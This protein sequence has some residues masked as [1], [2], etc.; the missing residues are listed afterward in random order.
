MER[1]KQTA[2]DWV[3]DERDA[4][5]R[6]S[7]QIWDYAELG[8]EE[9]K[10]AALLIEVLRKHGFTVEEGVADM[11][12]AFVAT[13][14]QGRPV[15][16]I[17]AEYDALPQCAAEG[18]GAGH[19]CG[20]N[21]YGTGSVA[22]A[23]AA[24]VAM[25]KAGIKGTVKLYGTPAEETLVG[26]VYM[27]RDGIF[28]GADVIMAWHPGKENA[29]MSGSTA[30]NSMTFEFYGK[31]AHAAVAPFDARGALDAVEVMNFAANRLRERLPRG[32]ML[33]YV[34]THGGVFPNVVPPYARSW[35]YVRAG[36]RKILDPLVTRLIKCAEGAAHATET[37]LKT[38]VI[39]GTY[40]LLWV[41]AAG[42]AIHANLEAIAPPRFTPEEKEYPKKRYGHSDPDET[43]TG[44]VLTP[45]PWANDLGNV[46]WIVPFG[47]FMTTCRTP[48]TPEHHA[49]ATDQY[50][51][52]LGEK[53]MLYAAKILAATTL[54]YMTKPELVQQVR[55]EWEAKTKG[56]VYDPIVPRGQKPPRVSGVATRD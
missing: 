18:Q 48:E 11:P 44:P 27:A 31:S 43:V 52:G 21:L 33:H 29:V 8:L 19:G 51:M 30:L 32:A 54:D 42:H 6:T 20:H 4:L 12:T 2:I 15:I 24:K 10:S 13:W 16:G 9:F 47:L 55:R 37:E 23:I 50:R 3:E 45:G 36:S 14:G 7:R 41:E 40:E 5:I 22:G 25:E 17:L 38:T 39:T 46:S 35:Y 26:K 28:D 49:S 34:I 1:A 56:F 53:G